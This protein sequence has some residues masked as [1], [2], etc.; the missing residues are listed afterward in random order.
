MSSEK[1]VSWCINFLGRLPHQP[2]VRLCLEWYIAL[3]LYVKVSYHCTVVLVPQKSTYIRLHKFLIN[4]V[5]NPF[6]FQKT[7]L[8]DD[9]V[10]L[11]QSKSVPVTSQFAIL[12]WV[13]K[14]KLLNSTCTVEEY[15]VVMNLLLSHTM[16]QIF[17][18]RLNAQ[19]LATKLNKINT[20]NVV[21]YA[22]IIG[23]IEKT[24]E[25]SSNDKNFIKL[26]GDFFVNNFDIIES[27]RSSFIYYFFPKYCEIGINENSHQSYIKHVLDD[28]NQYMN[29]NVLDCEFNKEWTK[30]LKS[31]DDVFNYKFTKNRESNRTVEN[32]EFTATLQKKYIPWKNMSD[33]EVYEAGK[34]VGL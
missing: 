13:L 31:Q 25:E 9:L 34:K 19:Y 2:S 21:K 7:N 27:L 12:Y 30:C 11:L 16:G 29:K 15:E 1:T 28:V 26:K 32:G 4:T 14:H 10:Q 8:N 17:S 6:L 5:N 23:V 18:V 33:I 3:H 20:V 24:F 22:Y